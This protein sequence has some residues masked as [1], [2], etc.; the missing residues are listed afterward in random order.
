M[1]VTSFFGESSHVKRFSPSC[2]AVAALAVVAAFSVTAVLATC[3]QMQAYDRQCLETVS[4]CAGIM[5]G[6]TVRRQQESVMGSFGCRSAGENN[7][8]C[9]DS[10]SVYALCYREYTC[11]QVGANCVRNYLIGTYNRLVKIT[12][13]CP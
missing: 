8:D 13:N 5:G 1:C 9:I 4:Q 11:K 3:P 2:L 10:P 12:S 6:C 7:T